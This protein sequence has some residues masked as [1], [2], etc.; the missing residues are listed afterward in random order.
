M[1]AQNFV[2]GPHKILCMAHTKFCV[3]PTQN[4]V[5][6]LHKILCE[7]AMYEIS[8][9]EKRKIATSVTASATPCTV[10]MYRISESLP[11]AK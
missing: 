10:H 8:C 5:W 6:I 7:K 11:V 2:Y 3:I 9:D 1:E 4:F